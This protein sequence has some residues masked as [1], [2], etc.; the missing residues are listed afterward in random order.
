MPN[1]RNSEN[2]VFKVFALGEEVIDMQSFKVFNRWG[3]LVWESATPSITEEWD[4][5]FK[6]T[7]T[8]APSDVYVFVIELL[9]P[10]DAEPQV[11]Q[12]EVTLIR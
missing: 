1:E 11:L 4:G 10:G 9:F 7:D 2:K 12:G 6:D 5:N 8:P 3:Q